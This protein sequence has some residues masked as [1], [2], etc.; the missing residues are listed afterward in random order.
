MHVHLLCRLG[1]ERVWPAWQPPTPALRQ[2]RA[3]ARER[4]SVT[5]QGARLKIRRHDSQHCYQP[6]SRTL[7]RLSAQQK[8]L[9]PQLQAIDQDLADLLQAEPELARKLAYQT[10]VPGISLSSAITVMAIT[11]MAITV[12]AETSG[13]ALIGN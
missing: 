10:S 5:Q 2:L 4:Q 13:F 1:L 12:V 6:N 3:L 7:E 9:L 11:V 8:L